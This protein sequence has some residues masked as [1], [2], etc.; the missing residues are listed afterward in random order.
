MPIIEQRENDKRIADK[1][2]CSAA[3]IP[4]IIREVLEEL[5]YTDLTPEQLLS[6]EVVE[7][8]RSGHPV[9]I[10]AAYDLLTF[11]RKYPEVSIAGAGVPKEHFRM[12]FKHHLLLELESIK[13]RQ[14]SC[15]WRIV[16][17]K[18]VRNMGETEYLTKYRDETASLAGD[19]AKAMVE[20]QGSLTRSRPAAVE[21]KTDVARRLEISWDVLVVVADVSAVGLDDAGIQQIPEYTG[22]PGFLARYAQTRQLRHLSRGSQLARQMAVDVLREMVISERDAVEA[23]SK[24]MVD[25][26]SELHESGIPMTVVLEML[27]L[28]RDEDLNPTKIAQKFPGYGLTARKVAELLTPMLAA[29][30]DQV[31]S[32]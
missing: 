27:R 3:D 31:R 14:P 13:V 10:R 9:G 29:E 6:E 26:D 30:H 23:Q 24:V 12:V 19:I 21:R 28:R 22:G 7:S 18:L 5:E 25:D 32:S 2:I 11:H 4:V 1:S 15:D 16:G 17:A 8:D 20:R